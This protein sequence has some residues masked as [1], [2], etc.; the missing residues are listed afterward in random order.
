MVL[1]TEFFNQWDPDFS[2]VFKLIE[3]EGVNDVTQ[4]ASDH[5]IFKFG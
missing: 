1:P 4:I 3:L 2:V 5:V